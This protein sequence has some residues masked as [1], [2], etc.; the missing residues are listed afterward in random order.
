MNNG[1]EVSIIISFIAGILTF[2]SPCV[3]PL[4]PSYITY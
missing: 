1:S 2:L 3:L 4:F